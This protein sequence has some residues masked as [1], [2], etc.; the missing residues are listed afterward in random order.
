MEDQCA[1]C[2][3]K[4]MVTGERGLNATV[5]DHERRIRFLEKGHYKLM[6]VA[7]LS[8][9]GVGAVV[10]FVLAKVFSG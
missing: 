8:G 1:T 9:G 2:P 4:Y 6:A 10:S 5:D 3:V 7:G